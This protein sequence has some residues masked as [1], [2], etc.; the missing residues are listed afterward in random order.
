M[1]QNNMFIRKFTFLT[2]LVAVT[3]AFIGLISEF[4]M[5]AFWATVLA[6]IFYSLFKRFERWTKGRRNLSAFLTTMIIL[7]AVVIPVGLISFAMVNESQ[8]LYDDFKSGN[9]NVPQIVESIQ[10]KLPNTSRLLEKYGVS[11]EQVRVKI[12]E[13]IANVTQVVGTQALTYTKNTINFV[14]QFTLMLYLLFFFLRDG[15]QIRKIFIETFPLQDE[16]ENLLL[17]RFASVAR[18]TMKGTLIVAIVQGTIGGV[19]FASLGIEGAIF[20][21]V[22]MTLLSLLPV[23]GSAIIWAPMSIILII[24][25]EI[26]KA[27]IMIIVGSLIIGLVDNFL[28]PLLVGRDTKMPDYLVL[29]ATLGG[30]T[31]FGLTG[32]I[33]GPVIAALFITCWQLLDQKFVK[34]QKELLNVPGMPEIENPRAD[35]QTE[36]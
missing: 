34:E 6:V 16:T 7:F 21:G 29:I 26:T 5:T 9:T 33:V 1:S 23:G 35:A 30:L 25:G 36:N 17:D 19:L 8:Q 14:I 15:H 27:I 4:L 2:I 32:F 3:A 24:Q 10:K 31:W 20:W 11:P 22:L 18:A 13:F 12:N 28:R